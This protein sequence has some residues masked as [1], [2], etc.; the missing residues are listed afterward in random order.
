[1]SSLFLI[2]LD[3]DMNDF[4]K[5]IEFVI[6]KYSVE[7]LSNTPDFILA[8]YVQDCLYCFETATLA[9]DKW[10]SMKNVRDTFEV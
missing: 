7:N 1:M 3:I 8:N 4:K 5:E 6:N 10:Y 2:R 9:R